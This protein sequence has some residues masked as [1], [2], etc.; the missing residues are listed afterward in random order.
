[1]RTLRPLVL[2][3]SIVRSISSPGFRIALGVMLFVVLISATW[4][5]T[6]TELHV[7]APMPSF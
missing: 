4:L 1:M 3:S 7:A 2:S 5:V 6:G